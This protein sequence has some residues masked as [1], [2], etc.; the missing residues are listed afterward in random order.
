MSID[1]SLSLYE[2]NTCNLLTSK[3]DENLVDV[4]D[5]VTYARPTR[6]RVTDTSPIGN[7]GET[8]R[9]YFVTSNSPPEIQD[10]LYYDVYILDANII[11]FLDLTFD[12]S[13]A[14]G[15]LG[16]QLFIKNRDIQLVTDS[17][18]VNQKIIQR[19][20]VLKGE[21][22]FNE[23]LGIPWRDLTSQKG[24]TNNQRIENLEIY[25]LWTITQTE[26]VLSV[27]SFD[28]NYDRINRTLEISYSVVTVFDEIEENTF[29]LGL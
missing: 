24:L 11:Q 17:D 19:L 22:F 1:L 14:V 7:I 12:T 6:V 23:T 10:Y 28:S 27:S 3:V 2:N 4:I 26:G 8:K 25:I 21:W 15:G 13:I 18:Q 9:V 29:L 20:N 16:D 5:I